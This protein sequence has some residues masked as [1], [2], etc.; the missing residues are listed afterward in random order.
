MRNRSLL[1]SIPPL[2]LLA[3]CHG[4]TPSPS[5]WTLLLAYAHVPTQ[6]DVTAAAAVGGQEGVVINCIRMLRIRTSQ[7]A[8]TF[9]VLPGVDSVLSLDGQPNSAVEAFITTPDSV[10]AADLAQVARFQEPGFLDTRYGLARIYAGIRVLEL[11]SVAAY[12][13]FLTIS[14]SP[15]AAYLQATQPERVVT[16]APGATR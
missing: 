12:P 1:A 2:L 5:R 7:P 10:T 3:A 14:V 16:R 13:R 4:T 8:G 11:D 9:R 15:V 6:E